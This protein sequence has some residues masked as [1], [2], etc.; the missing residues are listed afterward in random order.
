MKEENL[1]ERERDR[2]GQK[3]YGRKCI[4][5]L[6]HPNRDRKLYPSKSTFPLRCY[7]MLPILH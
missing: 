1:P 4:D 7:A 3:G 6:F 2:Q 5:K